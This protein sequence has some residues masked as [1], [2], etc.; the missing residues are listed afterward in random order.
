TAY[1]LTLWAGAHTFPW[2]PVQPPRGVVRHIVAS[3]NNAMLQRIGRDP[4]MIWSTRI[5]TLYG[6]V[7]LME[8]ASRRTANLNGDVAV[9]YGAQDQI[10]PRGSAVKAAERLP[11]SARTAVYAQGYHMLLRDLH[12]DIVYGDILSYL[13]DP[14][15]PFPSGAPPLRASAPAHVAQDRGSERVT[16]TAQTRPESGPAQANR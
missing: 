8:E 3:D 14:A 12:A 10:I 6:L 2:R 7:N 4:N 9:L 16:Q 11:A 1:S 13:H 15:A 5:D